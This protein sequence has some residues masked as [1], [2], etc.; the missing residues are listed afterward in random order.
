MTEPIDRATDPFVAHG[1]DHDRCVAEAVAAAAELCAAR[2]VRL[3]ALRRRVL[4]L[5]W[6]HHRPVGAY[7]LLD[8][9][10]ANGRAAAP[11]TVYRALAFLSEHGLVHRIDSMNAYLGCAAPGATHRA[12]FLICEDCG[13]AAE[14]IDNELR[15]AVGRCTGRAGFEVRTETVEI[16][17]VCARCQF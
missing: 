15:R 3:T 10:R 14:I 6:R 2:G 17:G 8:L 4:E 7:E 16:T 12:H 9:M 11:P 13:E 1:H 5:I